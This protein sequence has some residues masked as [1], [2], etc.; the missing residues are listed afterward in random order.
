MDIDQQ[1]RPETQRL[2]WLLAMCDM[3]F[4]TFCDLEP[5]Y[6]LSLAAV[7]GL[8]VDGLA[9]G[10]EQLTIAFRAKVAQL[11]QISEAQL[12]NAN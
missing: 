7:F 9:I 2:L 4:S 12:R 11:K 1:V 6:R 8:D 10:L 5:A 3:R